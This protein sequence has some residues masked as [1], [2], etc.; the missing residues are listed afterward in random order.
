MDDIIKI[1]TGNE[2]ADFTIEHR[3]SQSPEFWALVAYLESKG[4]LDRKEFYDCLN[5]KC[6]QH[7]TTANIIHRASQVD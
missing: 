4:V 3:L 2:Y 7:V 5:Q 1:N 6:S